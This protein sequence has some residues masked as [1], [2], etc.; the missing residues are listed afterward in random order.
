MGTGV[1]ALM[2][3]DFS[4]IWQNL[5][6]ILAGFWTTCWLWA[7]STAGGIVLGFLVAVA[8]RYGGRVLAG[9]L[10]AYVAIMRGTPFLVQIFLLYYGGPFIGISLTETP[11]GLIGLVIYGAAYFSEV[12]RA[13][14]DAV[15]VGHIEAAQ[16]V[17]LTR[18]QTVRRILLPEMALLV[19]PP[20][21][22]IA[23]ILIKETAVLSTITVPELTMVTSVI[24]SQYYAFV[25]ALTLLALF[26]WFLVEVTGRAGRWAEARLSRYRFAN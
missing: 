16:C 23:V 13:G 24:G 7:V 1:T 14:F 4:I 22:N 18:W 21:V 2:S 19:L 9:I 26:Y 8:R 25:E 11:T 17:G 5:P 12:F 15:P 10:G 6:D 3:F 20:S